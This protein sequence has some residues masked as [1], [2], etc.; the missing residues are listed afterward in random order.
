MKTKDRLKNGL[1]RMVF[2][3]IPMY[4]AILFGY[5]TFA[6]SSFL[7]WLIT[8]FYVISAVFK[9]ANSSF[10]IDTGNINNSAFDPISIIVILMSMYYLT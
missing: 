4:G 10:S 1:K 2:P 5:I 7:S 6:T 9:S 3:E 8:M